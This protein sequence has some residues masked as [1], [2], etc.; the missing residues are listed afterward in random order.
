MPNRCVVGGCSNT[1]DMEKGIALHIIPFFDDNR[2]EAQKRRKRWVNFVKVKRAKW[3]PTKG[4]AI[5]SVHFA[6]EDYQ[7]R[8]TTM[9]GQS[10]PNNARLNKDD[11]GMSAYPRIHS[12]NREEKKLSS[13]TRRK[14]KCI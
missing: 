4:S 11:F 8:F 14:V 13:R 7:R 10:K 6:P 5:C 2:P 1:P 9:E 3:Q 12:K